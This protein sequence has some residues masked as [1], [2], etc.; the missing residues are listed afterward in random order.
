MA[1]YRRLV[2]QRLGARATASATCSSSSTAGARSAPD[3]EELETRDH[4]D[5]RARARL[6]RARRAVDP[7][8]DGDAPGA[9]RSRSAPGS[10]CAS[11][12]RPSPTSTAGSPTTSPS[13]APGR[14]LSPREAALPVRAAAH[15]RQADGRRPRRRRGRARDQRGQGRL[16]RAGG[17]AGAAAAATTCPT[18]TCRRS[19]H[20][21]AIPIGVDEDTLSPVVVDFDAEPHFLVIGDVESGKS[22]LLRI[23][24]ARHH[25][26]W[27]PARRR[28]SPSTTGAA[29][30]ARSP[31]RTRS[32]TS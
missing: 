24:R 16:E 4:P 6:R 26:R 13:G 9:A 14:G 25:D 19:P 20:G 1:T 7:A 21:R 10:S 31:R 18:T 23:D 27:T 5:R 32:A 28:S 22:N 30:S 12:T 2:A 29:C 15:R 8:V 17:A 11:A 3:Y